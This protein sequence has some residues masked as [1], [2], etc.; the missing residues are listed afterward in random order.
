MDSVEVFA[1][2]GGQTNLGDVGFSKCQ[3]RMAG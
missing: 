2:E 1:G 3:L